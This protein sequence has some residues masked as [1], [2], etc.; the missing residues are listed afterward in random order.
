M[1]NLVDNSEKRGLL[2]LTDK[3]KSLS[4]E[5]KE[6]FI[7][8]KLISALLIVLIAM[9][10]VFANGAAEAQDS[11]LIK[12][13][14]INNDPNESGYRT[15]N[16]ADMRA[17]FTEENGYD[18]S[19]AYSLRNDEQIAAAQLFIQE[20][21]ITCNGQILRNCIEHIKLLVTLLVYGRRHIPISPAASL[22][23]AILTGM[24]HYISYCRLCKGRIGVAGRK[25]SLEMVP[26]CD[27]VPVMI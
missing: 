9:G 23:P 11:G 7:V 8:K 15:A 16:D 26:V 4:E 13:G 25:S 27:I 12:V 24:L 21:V 10:A 20:G 22:Y 1:N 14:I 5:Q 2:R 18:A 3:E 19:F 6:R 17:T